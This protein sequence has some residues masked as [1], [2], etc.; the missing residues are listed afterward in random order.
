MERKTFPSPAAALLGVAVL[1]AML[2]APVANAT[3]TVTTVQPNEP[4]GSNCIP[5][6]IGSNSGGW[7]PYAAFVYKN[8]P[9]FEI[10]AGDTLA[11][12]LGAQNNVPIQLEIALAHTATNGGDVEGEPF[13]TVVTNTE[14]PQNPFGDTTVGD[15]ELQFTTQAP[16]SFPGGGL[17]IRFG[18]PSA[19]YAADTTCT[20]VLVYADSTDSSGQFVERTYNDA[21]GLSPWDVTNSFRIGGFRV[22][23]TELPPPPPL[24][25]CKD[26]AV[27]IRGTEGAD[28]LSG[29]PA[30]DVIAGLGGN[31]ELSGLAGNDV[32]CGG[33][34]K[35]TL[36][37]GKGNDKLFGEAGKD[38]LKGGPGKDKLKGGPGKDKQFQ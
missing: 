24:P 38:T 8:V 27:T 23:H 17:I 20:G 6:G 16:F 30:A 1:V 28:K 25:A 10:A 26:K 21:N 32:I 31:D 19:S 29:T 22:T 33:S 14:T 12:D 37:G 18:N 2:S 13:H 7:T 4:A 9:A 35:D 15:F 5:F 34:G 3:T 36:N 11:F